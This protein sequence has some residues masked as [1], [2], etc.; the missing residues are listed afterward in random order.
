MRK[1]YNL[2]VCKNF[3]NGKKVENNGENSFFKKPITYPKLFATENF[4]PR[5]LY[6]GGVYINPFLTDYFFRANYEYSTTK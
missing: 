2:P 6:N 3:Y 4:L 1:F 5:G